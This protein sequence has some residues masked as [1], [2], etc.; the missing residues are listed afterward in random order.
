LYKRTLPL[1]QV[2][3]C[4]LIHTSQSVIEHSHDPI[5]DVRFPGTALPANTKAKYI[6]SRVEGF[7]MLPLA[8]WAL[9]DVCPVES[10]GTPRETTTQYWMT[11]TS[12]TQTA[13][14]EKTSRNGRQTTRLKPRNA[15]RL[16]GE[17]TARC[18][19]LTT[20]YACSAQNQCSK[21]RAIRVSCIRL[22]QLIVEFPFI[23][24]YDQS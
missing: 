9:E 12:I 5:I 3:M 16:K 24:G 21:S 18:Y 11:R 15:V 10:C 2:P 17:L 4:K 7:P 14:S 8:G 19:S 20:T 6:W 22:P 23:L 1:T 13:P